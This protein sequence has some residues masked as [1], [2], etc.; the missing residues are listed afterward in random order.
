MHQYVIGL[1]SISPYG[2][3]RNHNIKKLQRESYEDYESRTWRERLHTTPDKK[4]I[5]LP[6]MGFKLALEDTVQYMGEKIPARG[7]ER[8]YKNFLQGVNC[9]EH[10]VLDIGPDK[11]QEHKV[12]VP[13]DGRKGGSKRVWKSYPRVDEWEGQLV[14]VVLDDLITPDVLD[15]YLR[16]TGLLTGIGV[17]RPRRGGMW[18]KFEPTGGLEEVEL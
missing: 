3:G 12:F 5:L 17:W 18:G 11:A 7:N 15:R 4:H 9:V 16:F 2:A 1:R 13:A 6:A 8:W 14:F 10:L